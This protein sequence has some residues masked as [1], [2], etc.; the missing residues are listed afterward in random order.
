MAVSNIPGFFRL[1]TLDFESRRVGMA[2]LLRL[3]ARGLDV[4]STEYQIPECFHA[5]KNFS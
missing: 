3:W 4:R 2:R 5:G 1:W